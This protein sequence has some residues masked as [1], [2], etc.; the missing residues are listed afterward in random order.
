MAGAVM[1]AVIRGV[2]RRAAL[3]AGAAVVVAGSVAGAAA[4]KPRPPVLAFTPSPYS[5]GQVAAGRGAASQTFTLANSGGQATGRLRV[6]V[7]GAAVFTITGDTCKTLRPG[8][9]CTVTV[10]FAPASAGTVTATLTAAGKKPAATA[11][12][13]L[14]GTGALG[15]APG[16]LYWTNSSDGTINESNLN[17]SSPRVLVSGQTDAEGLAVNAS[18][19]YWTNFGSATIDEANL[20]GSNPHVIETGVLSHGVAVAPLRL[21]WTA[22]GEG[23]IYEANL[24][25][26]DPQAIVTDQ[27]DPWGVVADDGGVYW[28]NPRTGTVWT[29]QVDGSDPQIIEAGQDFPTGVTMDDGLHLYW[30]NTSSGTHGTIARSSDLSGGAVQTIVGGQSGP[31]GVAVDSDSVYWSNPYGETVNQASLNGSGPHALFT[32]QFAYE[33]AVGP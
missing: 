14:T 33:V 5:Y 12:V 25:G 27:S 20:D 15:A 28:T 26:S 29:S 19:L 31:A 13:A 10:R 9:K 21:Y 8:K 23:T 7:D 16:H 2:I 4:A 17:G 1:R 30:A 18:H 22:V 32:G 24:D 11:T 6:R 3:A